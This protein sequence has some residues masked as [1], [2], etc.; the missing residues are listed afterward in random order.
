ML[1]SFNNSN[2]TNYEHSFIATGVRG[3]ALCTIFLPKKTHIYYE[4]LSTNIASVY[5]H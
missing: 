5:K 4:Q 1:K 2:E 3:N